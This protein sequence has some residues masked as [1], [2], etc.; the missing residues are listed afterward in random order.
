ME[1]SH[2][3]ATKPISI[4]LTVDERLLLQQKAGN[5]PLSAFI[6][7]LALG[8][9]ASSPTT[10]KQNYEPQQQRVLLAQILGL[11]GKSNAASSLSELARLARM[12]ALPVTEETELMLQQACSDTSKIKT[13]LMKALQIKED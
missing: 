8:D 3:A 6:R 13:A 9:Q 12:G 7:G 10:R 4:R 11:L 5:K 2:R 1:K